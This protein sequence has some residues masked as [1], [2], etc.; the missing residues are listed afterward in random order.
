MKI[1]LVCAGGLSSS[2]VMKKVR[3]Y[4]EE[5]NEDITIDAIGTPA[6]EDS[7]RDYDVILAAP[8]VRNR[9]KYIKEVSGIPVGAMSPQ[10]YAIGNAENI[11]KLAK[12][13]LEN[14]EG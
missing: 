9:M 8:Q 2:I 3:K 11:I 10:D 4:G 12:S 13:L 5:N 1:L 14:K 6:V 7:W